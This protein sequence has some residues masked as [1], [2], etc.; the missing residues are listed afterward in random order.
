MA[1]SDL[2][3]QVNNVKLA[4]KN[5]L[6]NKGVDMA[7][8]PFTDYPSKI[9]EIG[10]FTTEIIG[11]STKS[12]SLKKVWDISAYKEVWFIIDTYTTNSSYTA[13]GSGIGVNCTHTEILKVK[14]QVGSNYHLVGVHKYTNIQSN[15]QLDLSTYGILWNAVIMGI[16]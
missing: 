12:T 5:A 16:K 2:L 10:G 8:V 11:V 1:I 14:E 9:S 7:N 3:I 13:H 6:I 4:I 15:S